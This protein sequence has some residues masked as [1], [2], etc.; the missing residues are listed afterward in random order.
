MHVRRVSANQR[1]DFGGRATDMQSHYRTSVQSLHFAPCLL[2]TTM[3]SSRYA[4]T[5]NPPR[6]AKLQAAT[7][8]VLPAILPAP[9]DFPIS[10]NVPQ[11]DLSHSS[12][13]PRKKRGRKP[14]TGI[15]S[16]SRTAREA[17]RKANHSRIEKARRGK[18]NDALMELKS[19]I[20]P[21]FASTVQENTDDEDEDEDEDGDGTFNCPSFWTVL[22]QL[23]YLGRA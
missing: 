9:P 14:T 16:S 8:T 17:V 13:P 15:G 22:S 3:L 11:F 23:F 7:T 18:I 1:S 20:P 6:R 19:L 5:V 2:P 21:D 12:Q 10:Q 4:A